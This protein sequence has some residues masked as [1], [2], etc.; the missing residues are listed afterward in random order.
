MQAYKKGKMPYQQQA[1]SADKPQPKTKLENT[2]TCLQMIPPAPVLNRKK[3]L[4]II[5][6]DRAR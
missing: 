4:H 3:T 5:S 1:V 6:V 2:N